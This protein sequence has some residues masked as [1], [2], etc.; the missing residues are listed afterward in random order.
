[1]DRDALGAFLRR[2]REVL[3]PDEVGLATRSGRRTP[4]LRREDVAFLAGMST[5]YYVRIEQAR[6]PVPSEQVLGAVA[7][8]LRLDLDERDHVFRLAGHP[9]PP[10][11]RRTDHVAPALLR[12]LDQ[13]DDTPAA[14]VSDLGDVLAQNRMAT[15]LLGDQSAYSGLERSS[16]YRWFMQ[17]PHDRAMC[18][19]GQL[20][21]TTASHAAHLRTSIAQ[22]GEDDRTRE[23]VATLLERSAEFREAWA[24]HDVH[25]RH[26]DLKTM[27]HPQLGELELFCQRLATEDRAQALL[28]F[29]AAPG[30]TTADKLHLLDV[31]G[32]TPLTTP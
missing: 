1:M 16:I 4:G 30:S 22:G 27:I 31:V 7:R 12:V 26:H 8:A 23:M 29:T 25:H 5:D 18:P 14:V 2:R 6:G 32:S 21:S 19:P 3:Q 24:R 9:V 13:L 10:R 15:A 11:S 20:E 17:D 28:V